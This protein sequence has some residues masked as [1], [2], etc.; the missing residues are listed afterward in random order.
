MFSCICCLFLFLFTI[1][2][3]GLQ[4]GPEPWLFLVQPGRMALW[5]H[6]KK[7]QRF[8]TQVGGMASPTHSATSSSQLT[9]FS[10]SLF[11][12]CKNEACEKSQIL[13]CVSSV[14][15]WQNAS[16]E[17]IVCVNL[18]FLDQESTEKHSSHHVDQKAD[19][20][21]SVLASFP[22]LFNLGPQSMELWGLHSRWVSP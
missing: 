19:P 15:L 9:L 10:G 5:S 22:S 4:A 1:P 6:V 13:P 16:Q 18:V 2:L 20:E 7:L 11:P 12:I 21:L 17:G 14:S 8:Q 3:P